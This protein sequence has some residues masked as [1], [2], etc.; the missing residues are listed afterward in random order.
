MAIYHIQN[1][2]GSNNPPWHDRGIFVMGD[3]SAKNLSSLNLSSNDNG[4]TLSGTIAYEG[5]SHL[6]F[7]ATAKMGV[8]KNNY[9]T[10]VKSGTGAWKDGGTWLMG[11]RGNQRVV[12][13]RAS[14][15]AQ[16]NL[17]GQMTYSGEGG[18]GLK[19]TLIPGSA[20]SVESNWGGSPGSPGASLGMG[21]GGGM[22]LGGGGTITL[23]TG[24]I[25]VLGAKANTAPIDIDLSSSDGGKTLQG[26]MTYEGMSTTS[27][28]LQLYNLALNTYIVQGSQERL[29]IGARDN[30]NIVKLKVSSTDGGLTLN[31]EMQYAGDGVIGFA[32]TPQLSS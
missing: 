29:V 20:Y 6:H 10:Q 13:M 27:V 18:I 15:D 23:G 14:A 25:M 22:S 21:S 26:T 4:H 16:G 32:G 9:Q 19:G 31:G 28:N 1:Q 17:V 3:Q 12:S 2:W 8:N 11:S 24:G 30:Q 7:L 5:G